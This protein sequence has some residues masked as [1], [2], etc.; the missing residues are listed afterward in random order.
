MGTSGKFELST[1]RSFP[2]ES[3]K[4]KFSVQLI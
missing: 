2:V 3:L 4:G 1:C